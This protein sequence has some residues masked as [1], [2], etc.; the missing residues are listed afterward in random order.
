ML[1][2]TGQ[3]QRLWNRLIFWLK[4][5]GY[6]I[7]VIRKRISIVSLRILRMPRGGSFQ[8]P[9]RKPAFGLASSCGANRSVFNEN[10]SI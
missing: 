6:G 10:Q 8:S 3:H 9:A 4:A 7:R 5:K 2:N 1:R